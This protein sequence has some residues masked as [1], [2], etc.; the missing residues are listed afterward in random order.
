MLDEPLV[1]AN[2][3][4]KNIKILS[5]VHRINVDY[6]VFV[7]DMVAKKLANVSAKLPK[8]LKLQVDSGYR[9]LD[10]QKMI[11]RVFYN[12]LKKRDKNKNHEELIKMTNSLVADPNERVSPHTT[13]GA[14]DVS[15]AYKDGTEINLSSPFKNY[16][17]EPV[18]ISEKIDEKAQELRLLLN[19][20]MLEEEFA[21]NPGEYWHFSYGDQ[22][23]ADYYKKEVL[24]EPVKLPEKFY[25]SFF[26]RFFVKVL[27][28][29]KLDKFIKR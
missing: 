8:D 6:P 15:L 22:A 17:D 3:Y 1:L 9:S 23:W 21:P 2:K 7:R 5:P 16:F 25:Y 27:L 18:L 24:Y 29:L 26:Y 19:K 14:V 4:S 12:N 10:T 28:K 13:G 11:W 20:I